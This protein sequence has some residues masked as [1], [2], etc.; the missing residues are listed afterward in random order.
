MAVSVFTGFGL[1][2]TLNR[3]VNWLLFYFPKK[4]ENYNNTTITS[5]NNA[6]N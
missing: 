3:L 2:F 4:K 1:A 6:K 5:R